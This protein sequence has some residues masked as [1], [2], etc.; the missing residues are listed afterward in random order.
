MKTELELGRDR[1]ELVERLNR[2]IRKLEDHLVEARR[3][4]DYRIES[5][6]RFHKEEVLAALG[7]G[8]EVIQLVE[9]KFG[10]KV[11]EEIKLDLKCR[12]A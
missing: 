4:C 11:A 1:E 12:R 7:A 10:R 2:D 9:E 6:K 3:E 5:L 8:D